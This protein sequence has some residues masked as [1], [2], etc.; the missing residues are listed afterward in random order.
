MK[1]LQLNI[2]MGRLTWAASRFIEAEKPDI[3]CL[4]EAYQTDANVKFPD[5]MFDCLDII[6]E[7]S[8]LEYVYFSPVLSMDIADGTA[9]F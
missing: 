6:K 4:Q 8:G 7:T 1:L 2:W 3:I 5:R 9:D